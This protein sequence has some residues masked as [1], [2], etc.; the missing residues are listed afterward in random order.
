MP[1]YQI[2]PVSF[3][4]GFIT[5]TIFWWLIARARPLLAETRQAIKERNEAAQLHRSSDVEDN[6]RRFTL[7][8]AQGMH[9][10]AQL[11]ALDEILQEPL[12]IAPPPIPEPG[13]AA[14]TMDAVG[15][16]LPY[17][18]VWPELAAIYNAVTM[19]LPQ[20]LSGGR[21]IVVTG[22]PGS[23][24]TVALAHLASLTA[25]RS[26]QLGDLKD[27]V[28][29]LLHV[30][31]IKLPVAD[32]KNVLD[33]I[34][35]VSAPSAAL[36]DFGRLNNF[37]Q[38]CFRGGRALLL[39]DGCD[40]LTPEGQQSVSDYLRLL[41]EAYP[42]TRVVTTGSFESLDGLIGLGFAPLA[43]MAWNSDRDDSFVNRW[44][45]LW[46]QFVAT[47]S[48]VQT[49]AE[50][51][52]PILLNSWLAA[53][54]AGLSP[55]ELTLKVW[56]A[57]GGDSL[58]PQVSEAIAT[59]IRRLAPS[60]TPL[61]ALETLAMQ[62]TLGSQPIF[63]PHKA[64]EWVKS[65]EALEEMPP[66]NEEEQKEK[67]E[68]E[69]ETE[70]AAPATPKRKKDKSKTAPAPSFG[71]LSK[72]ASSGLLVSHPN[73]KM[74]FV[75][76]VVGGF[77]AGHALSGYHPGESIINQP[78]WIGKILAL[79]YLA[80]TADVSGL[81][82]NMLEWSRLPM[83]RPL[84]TAAGWLKD[85]PREAVWRGKVMAALAALLQ[86]E[87]LPLS[88]RG[89]AIAAFALSNDPGA[90]ALFRQL[91]STLSFELMQLCALGSGALRDTKAVH[92]L[93][94][95]LSVPNLAVR[96]AACLALVSI[97]TNESLEAVARALL[98]G[99]ESLRRAAA[100]ALANDRVEGHAMLKDGATLADIL[101]R[102]A[103]VY[104]LARVQ[105]PWAKELL[106]K[107]R[108]EDE[109]WVVRNAA[110]EVLDN[111]ANYK[112]RAPRPL[113]EPSQTPWLIE[114]AGKQGIGISPGAPVTDILLKALKSE[115]PDMRLAALP[116][117]KQTP[118]E[119]VVAQLYEAMYKDDAEL[120]E[121]VY[122][123]L[124]EIAASGVKLPNPT[125]YGLS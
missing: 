23:G 14:A 26:D 9:L 40:E 114:F 56:G 82:N 31:D 123:T 110:S 83:H 100:E 11:F 87:G 69:S 65:F 107:M 68:S 43:I 52:D 77:L 3:V 113:G 6:H 99:D 41:F 109:Q 8:R 47:E 72:M 111:K 63:D 66:E 101:L 5:A 59:H 29:F 78:D 80:S 1:L 88:L 51:V 12:L 104:G 124:M 33:A 45:E 42:A 50:Q 16:A 39:L 53:D 79:H 115:D 81:V 30:A 120:R 74:R 28:P 121:A 2:E 84:L 49:G 32:Q 97:G 35:E 46:S 55:F 92:T 7:R 57:Y 98:N 122:Y 4:I 27:M 112:A 17:L 85:A 86:T 22:K 60:N 34:V 96:Q 71:L 67:A 48:W 117:L 76:P 91:A 125:Q 13:G 58:G 64:R 24:K 54:N 18:P 19:T 70:A 25:N 106:E 62:V 108:I 103:V 38:L 20:A 44:G 116:Y 93:E 73:N 21:N 118:N 36:L 105:E 75:H 61:A 90:A 37:I 89:Q 94:G 15:Q 10:A 119:G 102:R 95:M